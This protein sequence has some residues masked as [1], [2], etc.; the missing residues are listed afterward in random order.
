MPV[1]TVDLIGRLT[2]H[3]TM[4]AA[5]DALPQGAYTTFR[6]YGRDRVLRLDQHFARLV[7][8]AQLMG[9]RGQLDPALARTCIRAALAKAGHAQSRVRLTFVPPAFFASVEPFPEIS[10]LSYAAGVRCVTV[11]LR[12]ENPHA[13]STTFSAQAAAQYKT[14][15]AGVEEGL[16]VADDGSVLEG[17]SSNFFAVLD[18]VLYGEEARVLIGTTSRLVK[19]CAQGLLPAK[20]QPIHKTDLKRISEAFITSVSREVM[21]V[22][23]IDGQPISDGN[24]GPITRALMQRLSALVAAQ[25]APV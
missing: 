2:T 10:P 16:M 6:T 11:T 19:E 8:S 4:R 17:M 21:P 25:A 3:P 20:A 15:P 24:P 7:E 14:L 23:H 9:L 13:K 5:A 18:G 1:Q 12:R 22:V